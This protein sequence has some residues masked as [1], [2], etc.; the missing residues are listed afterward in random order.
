[1]EAQL[2]SYHIFLLLLLY[3]VDSMSSEGSKA[4][5]NLYYR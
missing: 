4:Y 5:V 2:A 3:V 1:M